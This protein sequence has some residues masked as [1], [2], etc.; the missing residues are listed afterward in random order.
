MSSA[1]RRTRGVAFR[2]TK[3][4]ALVDDLRLVEEHPAPILEGE[5]VGEDTDVRCRRSRQPLVKLLRDVRLSSRP[6]G[7]VTAHAR[8]VSVTD[9]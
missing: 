8:R 7:G 5:L 2:F 6:V 3:R 4:V 1:G 9:W